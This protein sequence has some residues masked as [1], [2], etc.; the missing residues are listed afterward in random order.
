MKTSGKPLKGIM[1]STIH[2]FSRI[3]M[4]LIFITAITSCS[5]SDDETPA[6]A[7]NKVA[8]NSITPNTPASLKFDE[9]VII[10]YDYEIADPDGGRIW[11]QPYTNGDI[12]PKYSYT[13]SPLLSGK[14]SRTVMISITSGADSVIVDQL[15]LKIATADGKQTVSESFENVNYTFSN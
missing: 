14:G 4:V 5:K 3:V 15:K 6:A 12:T 9:E 2:K 13:S 7:I 8:I 1:K 10:N 11:V